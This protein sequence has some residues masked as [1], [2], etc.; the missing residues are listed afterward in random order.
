MWLTIDEAA[1]Y[2]KISKETLYRMAQREHILA[3]KLGSQWL[4]MQSIIDKWLEDQ[5]DYQTEKS[6]NQTHEI[7]SQKDVA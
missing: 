7:R 5:R 3:S 2:L 6:S 1:Q 4:F